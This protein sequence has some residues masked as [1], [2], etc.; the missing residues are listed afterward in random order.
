MTVAYS[1]ALLRR[2]STVVDEIAGMGDSFRYN[3]II[4]VNV[5]FLNAERYLIVAD[6]FVK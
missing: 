1:V 5:P 6:E 2:L 3:R 4:Q